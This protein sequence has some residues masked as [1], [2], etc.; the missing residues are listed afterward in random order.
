MSELRKAE[1]WRVVALILPRI[2]WRKGR[3]IAVG[4]IKRMRFEKLAR[5]IPRALP[6]ANAP[7]RTDPAAKNAE[8]TTEG[9]RNG[10]K[11]DGLRDRNRGTMRGTARDSLRRNA[12]VMYARSEPRNQMKSDCTPAH[13][14]CPLQLLLS[15]SCFTMRGLTR[16]DRT[17][18]R[19]DDEQIEKIFKKIYELPV[20]P[21]GHEPWQM[22][23][24]Y[25]REAVYVC[26]SSKRDVKL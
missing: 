24:S 10:A 1:F 3:N 16:G 6:S 20:I 18:A 22:S 11:G 13:S 15:G 19:T 12:R 17:A 2:K 21:H 7:P 26:R 23:S 4:S 5:G 14:A 9:E 25:R 8:S